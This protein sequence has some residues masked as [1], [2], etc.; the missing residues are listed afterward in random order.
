MLSISDGSAIVRVGDAAREIYAR[1]ADGEK[2]RAEEVEAFGP[3]MLVELRARASRNSRLLTEEGAW[4][5]LVLPLR[6]EQTA[7]WN[8]SANL[9]EPEAP[10]RARVRS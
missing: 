1:L 5:R 4:L 8:S 6:R 2:V 3:R 7:L 9:S 10:G